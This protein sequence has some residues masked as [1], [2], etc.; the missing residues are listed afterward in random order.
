MDV[1]YNWIAY[2]AGNGLA[3]RGAPEKHVDVAY[4]AFAH[5]DQWGSM[6]SFLDD[7]AMYERYPG[8]I[9][10]W[11]NLFG[12][13][14]QDVPNVCDFNGDGTL[15][16]FHS[17]GTTWWM[18][19]GGQPIEGNE[20]PKLTFLSEA[21]WNAN[22]VTFEDRNGDGQ[23]D[24]VTPD[25]R[26]YLGGRSALERSDRAAILT[27][28]P[29]TGQLTIT[30][31]HNGV[32]AGE[33]TIDLDPLYEVA[34]IADFDGDGDSDILASSRYLST[35]STQR[36]LLQDGQLQRRVVSPNLPVGAHLSGL[37]DFDGDG[38]AEHLWRAA[39]GALTYL[40]F[41]GD[42]IESQETVSYHNAPENIA[43]YTWQV[44][45]TGDF[46]GD[47]YAD[48]VWR[49]PTAGVAIWYLVGSVH[50]REG[51]PGWVSADWNIQA[52]GD[53]DGDGRS[54]LLWRHDQG[55]LSIWF[56]GWAQHSYW[57]S[58]MNQGTL[59][60]WEWKVGGVADFDADGKSDILWRHDSGVASIWL[61]DGGFWQGEPPLFNLPATS[62]VEGVL[63]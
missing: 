11:G 27:R 45:A 36:L 22:Q 23:C 30:R 60:K 41:D 6:G 7:G 51:Y 34:G 26:V 21:T 13:D 40:H 18:Q 12:V 48:L 32:P 47:G 1:R 43:S 25:G 37:A 35:Q 62:R 14:A 8:S 49:H 16:H 19:P 57:P 15:D 3:I 38:V 63:R 59:T 20:F 4:N 61:M 55:W 9:V 5:A 2:T 29:A 53:F 42:G 46:D 39:N 10:H 52:V 58:W 44:Q 28:D 54:D 50:A 17:T 31:M 24:V 56:E 33:S